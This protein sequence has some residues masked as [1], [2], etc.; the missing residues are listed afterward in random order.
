M[1]DRYVLDA[2]VIALYFAG[3]RRVKR[4]IDQILDDKAYGYIC[5]VNLAEFCYHYAREFGLDAARTKTRLIRERPIRVEGIDEGLTD[6]AAGF[7]LR[8]NNYS[9][10]DCYLLALAQKYSA[11]PLT[12]DAALSKN[13]EVRAILIPVPKS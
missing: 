2:G 1:H 11:T 10:A 13:G 12:T 3:N 6:I 7:K 4:Y 8:H 5:E 9:L